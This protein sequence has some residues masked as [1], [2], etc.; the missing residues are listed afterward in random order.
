[1][2]GETDKCKRCGCNEDRSIATLEHRLTEC[3]AYGEEW[4]KFNEKMKN[5]IGEDEWTR[6]KTG[7][8]KRSKTMLALEGDRREIMEDTKSYLREVW[9]RR[10]MKDKRKRNIRVD[11]HNDTK[12]NDER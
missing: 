2:G 6:Q 4:K 5:K 11:E 1:M 10:N 7:N 8:D 9:K 12:R 3:S